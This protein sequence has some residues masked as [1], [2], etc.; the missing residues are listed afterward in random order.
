MS[1]TVVSP[2]RDPVSKPEPSLEQSPVSNPAPASVPAPRTSKDP[3]R[4]SRIPYAGP[5]RLTWESR[6]EV[7]YAQG[8]CIDVSESGLRIELPVPVP[9]ATSLMISA[10]RINVSG[11]ATVK[12][13]TPRRAK[14][15]IGLEL[16]GALRGKF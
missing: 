2:E 13:V 10:D 15:V 16:C 11:A 8:K 4:H 7:L 1:N 12:S 3:R 9:V 5:V 6:G 14:Y